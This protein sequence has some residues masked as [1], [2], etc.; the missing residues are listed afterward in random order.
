MQCPRCGLFNPDYAMRCDC[1]YDFLRKTVDRA[2]D[3][4]PNLPVVIKAFLLVNAVSLC[5]GL[6]VGIWELTVDLLHGE[7]AALSLG[8]IVWCV[9]DAVLCVPLLHRKN[10]ARY[11]LAI[12]AFPVGMILLAP[13]A[14]SYCYQPTP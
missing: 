2:F 5:I 4:R 1:G 3:K 9:A 13:E 8:L 7:N 11:A 6:G 14:Q 12:I 10:W